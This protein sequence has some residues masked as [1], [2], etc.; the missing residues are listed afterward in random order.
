[1]K[2]KRI[3]KKS[4]F[5]SSKWIVGKQRLHVVL[6]ICRSLSHT[7]L[8][9]TTSKFQFYLQF[10]ELS[11]YKFRRLDMDGRKGGQT[12][13]KAKTIVESEQ[14]SRNI[15]ISILLWLSSVLCYFP[16]H[17]QFVDKATSVS[18]KCF[19]SMFSNGSWFCSW[20]ENSIAKMYAI[21]NCQ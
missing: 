9:P 21:D 4:S 2:L 3:A 12:D 14:Q 8:Q 16:L 18:V 15:F 19:H 11:S 6:F 5:K 17:F 7:S 13:V 1:M 20:A 10:C